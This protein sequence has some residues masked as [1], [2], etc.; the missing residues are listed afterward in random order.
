MRRERI[1]CRQLLRDFA[2]EIRRKSAPA[3]DLGELATLAGGI[4]LELGA[5]LRDRRGFAVG[6][7]MHR[8]IFAD[9]H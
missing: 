6:L 9:G 4:R 1:V 2:G 3:V 5:L 7:R 8:D